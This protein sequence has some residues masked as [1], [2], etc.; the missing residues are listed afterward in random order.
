MNTEPVKTPELMGHNRYGG[1]IS[2]DTK[3]GTSMLRVD[4][5]QPD[6]SFVTQLINPSSI[7]RITLCDETLGRAAAHAGQSSPME[8][9]TIRHLLPEKTTDQ[10][11]HDDDDIEAGNITED[12][13]T[14]R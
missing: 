9:W 2:Q 1:K 7:Y 8:L 12:E 5:P 14:T 3:F 11:Y 4:V 6:G 10:A 13:D